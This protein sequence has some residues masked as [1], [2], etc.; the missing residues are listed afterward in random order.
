MKI[1]VDEVGRG[2][3]AG[4][5]YV[6]AFGTDMDD[7]ELLVLFPKKILKDSKKL[8]KK[9][10]EIICK[11]LAK[12]KKERRVSW[13]IGKVSARTID[14]EGVTQAVKKAL[15]RALSLFID[16]EHALLFLDGGLEAE[17]FKNQK[18]VI[19]GDEKIVVIACASIV[20]KVK[21]DKYMEKL[22]LRFPGYG[23][24]KNAGYGTKEH[25]EGLKRLGKTREHRNLFLRK[26]SV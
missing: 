25:V 23:F 10:R 16:K 19:K 2:S 9:D 4:A 14:R 26:L 18:S 21:R 5:L 20:A 3:F 22:A 11:K 7:K 12:L 24:E 6:C 8:S 17:D 1:G 15:A 13:N